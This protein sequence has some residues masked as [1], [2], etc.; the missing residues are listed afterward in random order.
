MI[1]SGSKK[2]VSAQK[3]LLQIFIIAFF[4][5]AFISL[6]ACSNESD[7]PLTFDT[8]EIAINGYDPVSY[9]K[10]DK[11]SR[12]TE[13]FEYVWNDAKYQFSCQENLELFKNNPTKYTPQYDG[14]CAFAMSR[15]DYS[16]IDPESYTIVNGK[17]YLTYNRDIRSTWLYDKENYIKKAD[18]IWEDSKFNKN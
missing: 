11:P 6:N 1:L 5:T 18:R 3:L 7:N 10:E 14:Y 15:G 9:F 8:T 12:G 2:R 17:L 4:A 16:R 13:E